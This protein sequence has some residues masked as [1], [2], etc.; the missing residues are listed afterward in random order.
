MDLVNLDPQIRRSPYFLRRVGNTGIIHPQITHYLDINNILSEKQYVFRKGRNT[1]LAIFD[2]L[3]N[4]H[5][6]WNENNFSSCVFVHFFCTFDTIDHDILMKKLRLYDFDETPLKILTKLYCSAPG[7]AT[8]GL[9]CYPDSIT[10]IWHG[11]RKPDN[12][13][14]G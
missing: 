4:L 12:R 1:S 10:R 9:T 11:E 13:T 3:K 5:A 6:N 7:P 2:V 8:G 14:L